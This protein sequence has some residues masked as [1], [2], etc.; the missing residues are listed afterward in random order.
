MN[1]VP[2][3]KILD[4]DSPSGPT[5]EVEIWVHIELFQVVVKFN[6]ERKAFKVSINILKGMLL[7]KE[8]A[9]LYYQSV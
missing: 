9:I 2:N 1:Q 8:I 7:T 3:N 5:K 4:T 6:I